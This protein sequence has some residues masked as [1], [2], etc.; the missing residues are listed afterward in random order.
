MEK[1]IVNL[2][3]MRMPKKEWI[4]GAVVLVCAV[5]FALMT[6]S[7]S[8]VATSSNSLGLTK[9]DFGMAAPMDSF[10]YNERAV[11]QESSDLYYP[12][13]QVAG[14]TAAT[15]DQRIIKTGYV[16]LQIENV[17]SG[18]DTISSL[19]ESL[20]GFV[21]SSNAGENSQGTRYGSITIRFPADQYTSALQQIRAVGVKVIDESTD[22]QDVTEQYTDL[23]ARLG[24][25]RGEEQAYLALLNQS[26]SVS[27][28]LS[29][30]RELSNVRARIESLQ[31]QIQYLEN[32][33]SYSTI[34]VNLQETER[35]SLP[36]KPFQP[37]QTLA[38]ALQSVVVVFQFLVEALIWIVI[39]GIGV[40]LPIGLIAWLIARAIAHKRN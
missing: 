19:A 13:P 15:A 9:S 17:Q 23:Q 14:E 34:T 24:V 31:G 40:V 4:I 27:D 29:V 8:L 1:L 16:S 3:N 20:G 28:L 37:G 18:I 5:A 21:Q 35:V 22:A 7:P 30:Q 2:S 25:A 36:T 10:A 6:G 11:M 33:T 38:V 12:E 32:H 26:G 39:L